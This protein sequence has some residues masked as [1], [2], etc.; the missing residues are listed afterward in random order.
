MLL[1][2]VC[3]DHCHCRVIRVAARRDVRCCHCCVTE[4]HAR[5]PAVVRAVRRGAPISARSAHGDRNAPCVETTGCRDDSSRCAFRPIVRCS[6]GVHCERLRGRSSSGR[7]A[8]TGVARTI[9]PSI[10][11]FT[12]NTFGPTPARP[13]PAPGHHR[14]DAPNPVRYPAPSRGH[15]WRRLRGSTTSSPRSALMGGGWGGPEWDLRQ[16]VPGTA[17]ARARR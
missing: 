16:S 9:I 1:P 12:V 14:R 13:R 7:C 11:S 2:R 8:T 4:L 5:A 17:G 15:P 6:R 10:S 3:F